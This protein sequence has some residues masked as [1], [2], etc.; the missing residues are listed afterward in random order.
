MG[1]IP[2]IATHAAGAEVTFTYLNSI[3]AASDFWALTPR[4]LVHQSAATSVANGTGSTWTAIAFGA[5]IFDIVQSGDSQMHDNTTD[6][7]RV[8]IRTT[9]KYEIT[10]QVQFVL[11][12]T[13]Y[14]SVQVR[15]NAAGSGT[16]GT[17]IVRTTLDAS[18]TVLT[19]VFLP[20][21]EAS[22][23]AGDYVE[24]FAQQNRGSAL[25]TV[26]GPGLT[27]LKVRLS[28]S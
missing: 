9:G 28:G 21:I 12:S 15:L 2:T 25:N 5:E 11:D 22:L 18:S 24:V 8:Y 1:T 6:N 10:G 14:R 17:E 27:F 16:G 13:G 4:A 26:P 3:K 19:S 20:P 23:V 7:S